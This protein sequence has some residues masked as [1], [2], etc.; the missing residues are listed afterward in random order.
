M[1]D[2]LAMLRRE[3]KHSASMLRCASPGRCRKCTSTTYAQRPAR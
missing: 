1:S 2:S 3:L